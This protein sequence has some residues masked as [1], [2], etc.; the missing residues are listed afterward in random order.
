VGDAYV[1]G[2]M[3]GEALEEVEEGGLGWEEFVLV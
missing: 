3:S 1:P 2:Y